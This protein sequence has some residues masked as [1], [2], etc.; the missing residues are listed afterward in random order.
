[1]TMVM[2]MRTNT[3]ANASRSMSVGGKVRWRREQASLHWAD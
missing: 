2:S 1:M 3:N